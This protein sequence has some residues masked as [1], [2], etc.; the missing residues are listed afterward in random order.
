MDFEE[1]FKEHDLSERMRE[2][3]IKSIARPIEMPKRKMEEFERDHFSHNIEENYENYRR[4]HRMYMKN[5]EK[6]DLKAF[7]AI[8][9]DPNPAFNDLLS[10]LIKN[11]AMNYE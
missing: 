8:G 11:E 7:I 4:D 6:E 9:R 2:R 3:K 5:N 1:F 10:D